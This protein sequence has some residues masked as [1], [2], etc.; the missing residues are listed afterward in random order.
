MEAIFKVIPPDLTNEERKAT[1]PTE[2]I[3]TIHEISY[4]KFGMILLWND[5][6]N[7]WITKDGGD[8]WKNIFLFPFRKTKIPIWAKSAYG[9]QTFKEG[10]VY[11]STQWITGGYDFNPYLFVCEDYGATWT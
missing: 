10:R 7:I 2:A 6:G 4:V 5:D 8:A 1:L 9:A 3:T 11:A